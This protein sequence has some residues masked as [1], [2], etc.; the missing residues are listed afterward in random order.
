MQFYIAGISNFTLFVKNSGKY[1]NV[2][3][4]PQKRCRQCRNTF[5]GPLPTVSACML[6]E[7]HEVKV[8]F[9]VKSAGM[10][11]SVHVTKLVVK[12]FDPPWPKNLCSTQTEQLY[13]L[14]NQSYCRLKFYI[15]G[16][17]NLVY[18]CDKQWKISISKLHGSIFYRTGVIAD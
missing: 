5:S 17:G 11:T 8:L 6:S 10:V 1:Q 13:I 15:A 7:L 3:F 9:Y 16:I 12:S 18:F 4:V 14:Q 2:P